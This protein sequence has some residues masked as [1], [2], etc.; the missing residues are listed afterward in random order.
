MAIKGK[1]GITE[2]GGSGG[3]GEGYTKSESD[4]K[5]L[6]AVQGT[7]SAGGSGAA[8]TLK[9]IKNGVATTVGQIPFSEKIDGVCY[10]GIMSVSQ[11]TKLD[12]MDERSTIV[13]DL[14]STTKT[15]ASVQANT[16]YNF[17]TLTELTLTAVVDSWLESEIHFTTGTTFTFTA[18]TLD[19][20]WIGVAGTPTFEAGKKYVISIKKSEAVLG[21]LGG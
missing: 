13:E 11:A 14:T 16:I 15:I 17:G 3:S 10:G 18:T 2:V 5:Y 7:M 6:T 21:K 8:F 1:K 12:K 20:K 9:Q 4:A 19:G